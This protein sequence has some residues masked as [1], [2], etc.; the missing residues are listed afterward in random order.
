MVLLQKETAW[1]LSDEGVKQYA[2]LSSLDEQVVFLYA[3][4]RTVAHEDLDQQQTLMKLAF[5]LADGVARADV[6]YA[7][8]P[9]LIDPNKDPFVAFV[10]NARFVPDA[11]N[12]VPVMMA[13]L[14]NKVNPQNRSAWI[15]DRHVLESNT[16]GRWLKEQGMPY[17]P[18]TAITL[19]NPAV[20]D[21]DPGLEDA[22][23]LILWLFSKGGNV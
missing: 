6:P 9:V 8:Y 22:R 13:I 14:Q 20:Y 11:P 1:F 4:L 23:A 10:K 18:D 19:V 2:S 17:L 7:A 5:L 15:Y 21:V 12:M 16:F 3:Y